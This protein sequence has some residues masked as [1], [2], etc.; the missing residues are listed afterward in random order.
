MHVPVA[1]STH[2]KDFVIFSEKFFVN[3]C[4]HTHT[5]KCVNNGVLLGVRN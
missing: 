4:V 5:D 1:G 2:S 3:T